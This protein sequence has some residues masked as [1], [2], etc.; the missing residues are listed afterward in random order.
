MLG[1]LDDGLFSVLGVFCAAEPVLL[2]TYPE[3]AREAV[4]AILQEKS[5]K[6]LCFLADSLDTDISQCIGKDN[7][8]EA[9]VTSG[10][11]L[12]IDANRGGSCKADDEAT[13]RGSSPSEGKATGSGNSP[14]PTDR[15]TENVASPPPYEDT[16]RRALID[17]YLATN[18]AAWKKSSNWNTDK[19]LSEWYGV[20]T[21]DTGRV[22]ELRLMN[23]NLTGAQIYRIIVVV[24]YM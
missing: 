12:V 15:A 11:A 20:V 19:P 24:R 4:E 6:E 9:L 8:V 10:K 5:L 16:D 17:F 22:L 2:E 7:L 23:N 13:G 3:V 14:T 18:G 1:D 21:D